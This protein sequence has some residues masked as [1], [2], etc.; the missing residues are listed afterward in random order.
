SYSMKLEVLM[1]VN[2]DQ[3][4]YVFEKAKTKLGNLDFQMTGTY[5]H[6]D[7]SNIELG[8][9]G[10]NNQ[11]ADVKELLSEKT[12]ETLEAYQI[13]GILDIDGKISGKISH[14]K[15]PAIAIGF[16]LQS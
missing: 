2:S 8:F 14:Q 4:S 5:V 7:E 10:L 16:V 12:R 6:G 15:T 13:K 11:L 9:R 3:N 1:K